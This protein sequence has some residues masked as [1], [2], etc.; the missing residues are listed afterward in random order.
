VALGRARRADGSVSRSWHLNHPVLFIASI[1]GGIAT[2]ISLVYLLL[3][4]SDADLMRG[5]GLGRP[6]RTAGWTV[7][8]IVTLISIIYL[9][10]AAIHATG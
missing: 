7:T 4:A 6:L 3:I 5:R 8:L 2:P 10:Q 9:I 1:V